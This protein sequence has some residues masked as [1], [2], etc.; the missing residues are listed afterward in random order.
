MNAKALRRVRDELDYYV[1]RGR[2]TPPSYTYRSPWHFIAEHGEEFE[3]APCPTILYGP[4]R[5]CFGNAIV[6][7]A[8][9]GLPYIEGHACPRADF[10]AV[11]HAWN[12][13]PDGRVLDTTW[14]E[15]EDGGAPA[16]GRAY[17]GVRFSVERAH[18]ATWVGDSSVLDDFRRRWPVLRDPWAGEESPGDVTGV[19]D[20]TNGQHAG[21]VERVRKRAMAVP[22]FVTH[23]AA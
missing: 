9:L 16:A 22:G 2:M 10:P 5:M 20:F 1:G 11:H 21:T 19:V 17:V 18:D 12:L 23:L 15:G 4:P 14:A 13:M 7:A 6:V 8:S 3:P